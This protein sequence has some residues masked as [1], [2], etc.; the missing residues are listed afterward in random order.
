MGNELIPPPALAPPLPAAWSPSQGIA[1]WVD[2]VNA[3]DRF[4]IAA[5]TRSSASDVRE[6]YRRWYRERMEEHDRN[7]VHMMNALAT[8]SRAH[9][10]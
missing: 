6:A 1:L 4:L 7:L 5:L 3:C 10:G 9:D 8:R 2:L